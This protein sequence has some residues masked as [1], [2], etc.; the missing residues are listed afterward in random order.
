M[1]SIDTRVVEMEFDNKQFQNGIKDTLASLEALKE[2]LKLEGVTTGLENVDEAAKGLSLSGMAEAVQSIAEKFSILGVVGFTIIQDL[3]RAALNFAQKL[4]GM[5]LDPLLTGGK[6]RA[7]NIEQAQFMFRGLGMDIE[8]TMASALEAVKGTAFGLDEAA[9]AASQFGASGMRAGDDMTSALRAISGVA[10]MTSSSYDD[11][12]NVFTKVA[13]NGRVMGDDL[14]RLSARGLNAAATLAESLGV[15][16]SEVRQLVTEG[17]VSF[18]DFYRAMDQAFGE[19]STKA[20]ETYTGSLSNMNAALSRIGASFFGERLEQQRDLFNALTPAID[21]VG[22]AIGPAITA[23]LKF[24]G[25]SN[26]KLI[27]FLNNLDFAPLAMYMQQVI[28]IAKNVFGAIAAFVKPIRDAF[29]QIFPPASARQIYKI[30][31]AISDFTSSLKM[32][33]ESANN[34]RRTFAG[35]FAVLGIGWEIIKELGKFLFDLFGIVTEGSGGILEFTGS[36]GDFLV[37]LHQAVKSGEGLTKFFEGLAKVIRKPIEVLKTLT[38]GLF[39][40]LSFD[41]PSFEGVDGPLTFFQFISESIGAIFRNI[42]D[43]ISKAWDRFKPIAD[44]FT[45]F[46]DTFG[47][48]I[49][50]AFN[51]IEYDKVLS[52]INTGLFAGLL[53]TIRGFTGNLRASLVDVGDTGEGFLDKITE[54]FGALTEALGTMQNTLRAMTLMQIAVAVGILAASVVG[55]S[56]VDAEGLARALAGLS[57]I[58]IQLFSALFVFT[59]IGGVS[60]LIGAGAGMVVLATAIRV[61]VSSVKALSE[62]DWESL[63]KGLTGVAALLGAV[64]A[65]TKGIAGHAGGMIAAGTG[66]LIL[67]AGIKVLASVVE[68]LA[69]LSWEDMAKGIVG[70]GALLSSLAIFTRL[71]AVGSTGVLQGAGIILLATGIKVLASAAGD[72]AQLSWGDIGKG[73]ATMGAILAGF[74]GFSH[75]IDPSGLIRTGVSLV[76]IGGAM[77]IL[78]EAMGKFANLSWGEIAGGLMGMGTALLMIVLALN[79][80]PPNTLASAAALVAVS[81]ALG[82]IADA[83]QQMGGMSWGDIAKGLVVLAGSL[84]IIAVA[85]IAMTTA[86]PGAAATLVVAAAL[87]IL[88]PVLKTLGGMSWG[89]IGKGLL[90]LAGAFA[91]LGLAG[92]ILTPLVPTLLGL[93]VALVLIGG[94]VFLVGVGVAALAAGLTL[95]AAAGAG[96]TVAL[97]AMAAGLIGLIPVLF[98][99][100]GLGLVAFAEVI[101]SAGPE[102]IRAIVAILDSILSAIIEVLPKAEELFRELVDRGLNILTE[103]IPKIAKAALELMVAVL[104]SV[105]DNVPLIIE[106]II[107]LVVGI[108]EELAVG[109]PLMVDAAYALMVA[110]LEEIG[111]NIEDV[112]TAGADIIIAVIRGIGKN[113]E[114]IIDAAMD[115]VITFVGGLADAIREKTPELQQEGK[116]LAWA[117]ADGVTFGWA[118]RAGGLVANIAATGASAIARLKEKVGMSSPAKEFIKIGEAMGDGL[119]IGIDSTSKQVSGSAGRLGDDAISAMKTS[120]AEMSKLM[121]GEIDMNPVITPVLDLTGIREEASKIGTV[122]SSQMI[123]LDRAYS[124]ASTT[125]AQQRANAEARADL[126]DRTYAAPVTEINYTQHNNSPKALSAAEI[127]R[128]TRNQLAI[129]KG[130]LRSDVT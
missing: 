111:A 48:M 37:E 42:G 14:L 64:V 52:T 16:E 100:L 59:K 91:I 73:L 72:F 12:A 105:A 50:G 43:V 115:T 11:I 80:M 124:K 127:Y 106:Q 60:G 24:T 55:L 15:T 112:I 130:A 95:L 7:L 121:S 96:A 18:E 102:M 45:G 23:L 25:A 5:I 41:I 108:L 120:I 128:Q 114:R 1:S 8:D 99:N 79:A 86:L 103:Y 129:T 68:D 3:T 38:R 2:G 110:F 104:T 62:L 70:V 101:A 81:F 83:M 40:F 89:E 118:S 33:E 87:A 67:S 74:A 22:E 29:Q 123:D 21:A 92:L 88:A 94:A 76:I 125:S 36:I 57:G 117:I 97:V 85:M 26:D 46:F 34:L 119:G 126:T 63:A 35:L 69:E 27:S 30:F 122:L 58:F 107:N 19:N 82:L 98:E 93:G 4:S 31:L 113:L 77:H 66:L 51:N 75:I 20:N 109:V 6:R 53:A 9:K 17:K 47:S 49:A 65:A 84:L 56:K 10:A 78:A 61:L 54:P 13:G 116:R 39:D 90:T 32:G 44:R 28:V 71:V